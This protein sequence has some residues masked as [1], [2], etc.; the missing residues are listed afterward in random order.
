MAPYS[1]EFVITDHPIPRHPQCICDLAL[2]LDREQYIALHAQ[3]QRGCVRERTQACCKVRQVLW[4]VRRRRVGLGV[5]E[6]RVVRRVGRG[7]GGLG[8]RGRERGELG[9]RCGWGEVQLGDR[10][11]GEIEQIHRFG[12][13]DER[14]R[15]VFQAELLSLGYRHAQVSFSFCVDDDERK[16]R[17]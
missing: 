13:V 9:A 16:K 1:A 11:E 2:L 3:D 12:D 14:I 5:R 7:G 6:V 4:G 15:V 17:T 8:E 10:W